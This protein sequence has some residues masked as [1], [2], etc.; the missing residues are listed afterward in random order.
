MLLPAP[1]TGCRNCKRN[2]EYKAGSLLPIGT[3]LGLGLKVVVRFR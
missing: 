3:A 2:D 1:L